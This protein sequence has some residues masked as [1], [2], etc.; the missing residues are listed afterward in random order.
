MSNDSLT[1]YA[2]VY[3][4]YTLYVDVVYSCWRERS[5][6]GSRYIRSWVCVSYVYDESI[7]FPFDSDQVRVTILVRVKAVFCDMMYL[8]IVALTF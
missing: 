1:K 7:D 2:C 6:C 8:F 4:I 5:R 3:V